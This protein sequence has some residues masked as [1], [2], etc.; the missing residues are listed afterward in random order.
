MATFFGEVLP[1]I[2]RAVDDDEDDDEY[3]SELW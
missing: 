2:S 3:V 1:V